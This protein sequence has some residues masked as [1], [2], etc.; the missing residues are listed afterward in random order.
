MTSQRS[1][2]PIPRDA[3]I[4]ELIVVLEHLRVDISDLTEQMNDR[5]ERSVKA[6]DELWRKIGE[7]EGIQKVQSSEIGTLKKVLWI[8]LGFVVTLEAAVTGALVTGVL[9]LS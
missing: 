5:N 3:G 6:R 1:L 9:G 8:G 4:P 2:P 7:M